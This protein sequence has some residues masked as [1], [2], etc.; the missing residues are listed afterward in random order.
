MQIVTYIE[1]KPSYRVIFS[2]VTRREEWEM[3]DYFVLTYATFALI[4][5]YYEQAVWGV[6]DPYTGHWFDYYSNWLDLVY[7]VDAALVC[8]A[9]SFHRRHTKLVQPINGGFSCLYYWTV[10]ASDPNRLR[11][12][13][14][15]MHQHGIRWALSCYQLVRYNQPVIF[16]HLT[17][18]ILFQSAYIL[19]AWFIGQDATRAQIYPT[20]DFRSNPVYMNKGLH[21]FLSLLKLK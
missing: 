5:G 12:N 16:S 14:V 10:I 9:P 8:F 15:S 7:V 2:F 21:T 20:F 3:F 17:C 13:F 6:W 18:S 11:V 19:N 1:T 4:W